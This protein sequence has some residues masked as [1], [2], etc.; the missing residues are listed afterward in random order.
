MKLNIASPR[1]GTNICVE[2]TGNNERLLYGKALGDVAD[3]GLFNPEFAGWLVQFTGGSDKQGFPMDSTLNT[4]KR[5]KLLRRKEDVGY[6]PKKKGERRRKSVRGAVISEETAVLCMKVVNDP[7]DEK[8]EG[9]TAQD[10]KHIPGLTDTVV[11]T[12]HFP[13]RLTKLRRLLFANEPEDSVIT[14][15]MVR[16]KVKSLVQASDSDQKKT[17]RLRITRI[18]SPYFEERLQKRLDDKKQRNERS[19]AIKEEFLKK[20]PTWKVSN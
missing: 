9:Q 13:K 19:N 5:Q 1:H 17:P 10:V 20:Y 14:V 12:S 8:E 15:E 2:V 16:E 7:I 11:G 4:D 6:K 18:R 3:A